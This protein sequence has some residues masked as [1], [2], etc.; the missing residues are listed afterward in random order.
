M[1]NIG[2]YNNDSEKRSSFEMATSANTNNLRIEEPI[3]EHE[4]TTDQEVKQTPLNESETSLEFASCCSTPMSSNDSKSLA[5]KENF[6]IEKV[7]ASLNFKTNNVLLGGL[8]MEQFNASNEEN[9]VTCIEAF[10]NLSS[11]DREEDESQNSVLEAKTPIETYNFEYQN[12]Q[13][14]KETESVITTVTSDSFQWYHKPDFPSLNLDEA[15]TPVEFNTEDQFENNTQSVLNHLVVETEVEKEEQEV[16]IPVEQSVDSIMEINQIQKNVSMNIPETEQNK[17]ENNIQSVSNHAENYKELEV[18]AEAEKEEQKVKTPVEQS[19]DQRENNVNASFD[20]PVDFDAKI[21]QDQFENNTQSVS[22]NIENYTVEEVKLSSETLSVDS[23]ETVQVN[24]VQTTITKNEI[25]TSVDLLASN[26]P[27]QWSQAQ[28]DTVN[29]EEAKTP[30]NVSELDSYEWYQKQVTTEVTTEVIEIN[31]VDFVTVDLK[32]SNETNVQTQVIHPTIVENNASHSDELEPVQKE[33]DQV[34]I[35][36]HRLKESD[37]NK[38]MPQKE[39]TSYINNIILDVLTETEQRTNL[40][41]SE[42]KF[43]D[44][45]SS[46]N[47]LD[48]V[49]NNFVVINTPDLKEIISEIKLEEELKTNDLSMSNIEEVATTTIK[50]N[51]ENVDTSVLNEN[52]TKSADT[53]AKSSKDNKK[54]KEPPV[55]CFGCL[56]L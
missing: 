21:N 19:V 41:Q 15:K 17:F 7:I 35:I 51:D 45:Y 5:N 14:Q 1:E 28:I 6:S 54:S 27:Y 39:I 11:K 30:V 10:N 18:V 31:Q 48:E 12:D 34:I 33:D 36:D 22:N 20:I 56:I 8:D 43:D 9:E 55:D 29:G 13:N 16:K 4:V 26:E 49:T 2:Y 53:T 50:K 32:A 24:Q 37:E 42:N 52:E 3:I 40:V 25:K 47:T 38:E 23:N 44:Q 46:F